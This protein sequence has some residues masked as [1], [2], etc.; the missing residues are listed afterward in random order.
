MR[1][2]GLA[3]GGEGFGRGSAQ[4]Y[5]H[6]LLEENVVDLWP[7]FCGESTRGGQKDVRDAAAPFIKWLRG[8]RA[9]S[10]FSA[11]EPLDERRGRVANLPVRL[12]LF[13]AEARP[14]DDHI[15]LQEADVV[16]ARVGTQRVQN[17][18]PG[19]GRSGGGGGGA[20]SAM[21]ITGVFLS[22]Q[23]GCLGEVTRLTTPSR[24]VHCVRRLSGEAAKS[25]RST[26][27]HCLICLA[28]FSLSSSSKRKPR[29]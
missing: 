5:R 24:I 17:E 23:L 1:R 10:D 18:T 21:R 2:R 7:C 20:H 26:G 28:A 19:R 27:A 9:G 25:S 16:P 12:V 3:G 22:S 14:E 4:G 8:R 11:A 29:K 15:L 13:T 6:D